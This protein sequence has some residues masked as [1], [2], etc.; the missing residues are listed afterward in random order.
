MLEEQRHISVLE[1]GGNGNGTGERMVGN[2]MIKNLVADMAAEENL[3]TR[4]GDFFSG[5]ANDVPDYTLACAYELTKSDE[6]YISYATTYPMAMIGKIILAQLIFLI[7]KNLF[8][9]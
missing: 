5:G 9:Y 3:A 7:G 4:N 6:T 1:T 8:L 2:I